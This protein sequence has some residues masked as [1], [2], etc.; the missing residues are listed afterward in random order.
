MNRGSISLGLCTRSK[1]GRKPLHEI[2]GLHTRLDYIRVEVFLKRICALNFFFK[3][4]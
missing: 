4:V 2:E 3:N 1:E